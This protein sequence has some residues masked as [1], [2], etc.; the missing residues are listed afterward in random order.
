MK[1][2]D[3]EVE[4]EYKKI[5][6]IHLA[7]YPPDGRVHA[8]VPE[9]TT[10]T[11]I[12]M[13]VLSK[14]VWLMEKREDTTSYNYQTPRE[15]VS[16]EAHY[17]LGNLYRLRVDIESSEIQTVF[18]EGDYIVIRCRKKENAQG[19]LKEW[20][21][22]KL[23]DVLPPLVARWTKRIGV[24]LPDFDVLEM[25]QRWGSCSQSKKKLIFNL[26][27][28]KKP[29]ECIEYIVAHE[30]MHLIERTHTNRF[31]RLLTAYL[32]DWERLKNLLNEYPISK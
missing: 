14:W 27:L 10:D 4:I 20:Y 21:R 19:L 17:Y 25:P 8:S 11:A 22:Q 9:G 2:N 28:A 3:I 6:H 7:V 16:G 13:F 18:I 31:F 15:Y 12:R 23:K 30:T 5:K 24:E 1:I 32:P 29:I 26:E